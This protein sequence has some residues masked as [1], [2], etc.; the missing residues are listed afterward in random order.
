[1]N[2]IGVWSGENKEVTIM[3]KDM[4]KVVTVVDLRVKAVT[5]KI[6]FIETY[7]FGTD[8]KSTE[9]ILDLYKQKS[10][11]SC[12]QMSNLN[13]QNR[14][15]GPSVNPHI[16]GRLQSQNTMNETKTGSFLKTVSTALP[17]T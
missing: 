16:L 7:R 10:Y 8:G 2:T 4:E 6:G 13:F 17:K 1:M 14:E 5:R 3:G 9:F 12:G 15:F 11:R